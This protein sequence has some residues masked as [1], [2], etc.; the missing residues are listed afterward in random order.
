MD[1][2]AL[3]QAYRDLTETWG[4]LTPEQR[5][6]LVDGFTLGYAFHSGHME[7][8]QITLHD[9]REVFENGRVVSF[10]GDVRTLFEIQN[11]KT[12][13][14]WGRATA[15]HG[16]LFDEAMVLHAHALLTQGTYD[17]RRW[18]R[19]ERP[20]SYK[21]GE[22]VVGVRGVGAPAE[23][24]SGLVWDL[25]AEVND[26]LGDARNALTVAAYLHAGL[27][28]IHPFADG[29]GRVARLL[30]NMALLSM[31]QPPIVVREQD[32]IAYYGALDVFHDCGDPMPFREF[33]RA[34]S[35]VTWK[36]LAG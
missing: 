15:V 36:G 20:G 23:E 30:M 35:L 3:R 2:A 6:E 19:G 28:D 26:A 32:R 21:V 5:D 16:L 33:L 11:L 25:L 14:E 17:E 10:T 9:T 13:W 27:V 29:N 24:V 4:G 34:E 1:D 12:S 31:D 8:D 7:N 22:Y 18:S